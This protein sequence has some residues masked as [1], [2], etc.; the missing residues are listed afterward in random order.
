MLYG[1][2]SLYL[3][4]SYKI[5]IDGAEIASVGAV[6]ESPEGYQARYA[7]VEAFF[8]VRSQDVEI[9]V[10]IANF[11]HRRVRL[12]NIWF[13]TKEGILADTYRNIISDSFT[14]GCLMAVAICYMIFFILNTRNPNSLWLSVIAFFTAMR[15]S[16]VNERVLIRLLPDFSPEW[17]M[18]LGYLPA[19]ILLPLF[20]LYIRYL[21]EADPLDKLAKALGVGMV[22]SGL[23]VLLTDIK[24][25]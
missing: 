25:L 2:R 14:I 19:F 17:M 16:I 23:F 1:I 13:G 11:H 24:G 7:P 22:L 18:K 12:G 21:Y 20:I 10:Q 6:S 8:K 4:S 9:I 3:A 15:G 5:F